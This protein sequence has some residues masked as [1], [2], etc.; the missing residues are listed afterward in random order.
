MLQSDWLVTPLILPASEFKYFQIPVLPSSCSVLLQYFSL[1]L[2]HVHPRSPSLSLL[3]ILFYFLSQCVLSFSLGLGVV[4]MNLETRPPPCRVMFGP[5]GLAACLS[6][7][8]SLCL[9]A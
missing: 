5:L 1:S 7:C 2:T 8:L 4:R 3:D 9:G 6:F